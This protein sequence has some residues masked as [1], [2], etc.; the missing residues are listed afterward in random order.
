[1]RNDK[2]GQSTQIHK[3]TTETQVAGF[4]KGKKKLGEKAKRPMPGIP[5]DKEVMLRLII[6]HH[7]NLSQVADRMGTTRKAIRNRCDNDVDLKDTL[8]DARERKLD[9]LEDSV[10]RRAEESNDTGL[11]C[12]LLKT[13]ARHRGY[14]QD[15]SRTAVKD[16]ANEAFAFILSKDK[17]KS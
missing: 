14:D 1:M 3:F 12:F 7:G 17:S 16:I 2:Y 13:Q 6:E 4:P 8:E 9:R 11:Q 15:E 10:W 5:L